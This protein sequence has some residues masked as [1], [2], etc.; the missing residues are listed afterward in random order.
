MSLIHNERTKLLAS[1]FDRASTA[2]LTV[3][4]LAPGAAALYSAT[5]LPA[6][7]LIIGGLIWLTPAIALHWIAQEILKGLIE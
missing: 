2:C 1:A 3:G 5:D 7:L 6:A 4:I